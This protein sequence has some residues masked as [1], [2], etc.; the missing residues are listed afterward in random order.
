MLGRMQA[1]VKNWGEAVDD[2]A[3][4]EIGRDLKTGRLWLHIKRAKHRTHAN[5]ISA[6]EC[7][8]MSEKNKVGPADL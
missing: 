8:K 3:L 6:S 4:F 5:F 1:K 7:T 2:C